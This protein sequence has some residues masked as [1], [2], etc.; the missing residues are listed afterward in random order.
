MTELL[1]PAEIAALTGKLWSKH[2]SAAKL[3]QHSDMK[4]TTDHYYS[5]AVKL[6]A[7]R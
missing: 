5:K 1:T 3:L 2:Q 7:V 4:T 6:R